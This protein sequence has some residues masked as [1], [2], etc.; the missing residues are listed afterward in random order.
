MKTRIVSIISGVLL[1]IPIFSNAQHSISGT[2]KNE[3]GESLYGAKVKVQELYTG[4]FTDENGVYKIDD[5]ADGE[6][7]LVVSL[8]G[9][10]EW[11]E[12]LVVKG[13]DVEK[14]IVLFKSSVLLDE[15]LAV[16]V[17]A[18]HSTPTT[19]KE[20]S[21]EDIE[22]GNFGQDL[23]YLLQMTPS[24]V[25]T[26]DAGAGVGYTGI[27]IRGV[28]PTRTNVTVNGIPVNDAES[29]GTYWVDMPDLASSVDNI[30]VQRGVGT[31]AN[32]SA[33]FGASINIQMDQVNKKAYGVVDNSYGSFNTWKNTVK[34]G[35]GLIR[36]KF[37]VD[38]RFSRVT[39]D[40]YIDRA[41]S[42]LSSMYISGAWLGKNSNLRATFFT[43]KE[44]TYQAWWGVPGAKLSGDMDSLTGHFYN[45]YYPGGM[46][47]TANDSTNLFGSDS[48]TYNFYT[49][50]NEVDDY[51]QDYY[52]LHFNHKFSKSVRFNAALHYTRGLGY[53]EQYRIEDDFGTYGFD[54]VVVSGD[55]VTTTDLIRRR[56][57]DNHF[58]G[59]IYS[60]NYMKN[61]LQL[62]FGGGANQYK[63]GHYG[64][65]IWA[66]L[67]SNSELGDRF[68]D[69]DATK[70]EIQNYLKATWRNNRFTYFAD[71]Q[72]RH[73]DYNFLG[74][75]LNDN[76]EIMPFEQ[77]VQ[78]NFVNPKAGL[79]FDMNNKNNFYASLAMANRE[80]VRNDFTESTPNSRPSPE[81]LMDIEAGYHFTGSKAYVNANMFYMMYKDQL[82]LTGSVNDVGAY[83]RTNVDNSYRR[84]VEIDGGYMILS[85]LSI[86]LNLTLS[87][88]KIESFTE[89]VDEFDASFNYLGQREI[90]HEN[91]DLAFSPNV[92][93]GAAINY[94]PV[95]G[96]ELQWASKYV[97]KQYLDNTMD[98]TR[99]M[100]AYFISN[101]KIQYTLNDVFF[102]K[103]TFGVLVNNLFNELYENNGYTWGYIYDNYRVT[104]NFY[105]PQAGR[106]FLTRIS[107]HL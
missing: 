62:T 87:Q 25:V 2:V 27:R 94:E 45:N 66:R 99:K 73:V 30:Q 7:T 50:K 5:L 98:D 105:Y 59:G 21:K 42:N 38:T 6:Y 78:F 10:D 100:D 71:V 22:K 49:Y 69:N 35:T 13:A 14:N 18:Q 11:S 102:K 32:G 81:S 46:Y 20:I 77:N 3:D 8:M 40:G 41:T 93:G 79:M 92:I 58:Y 54:P 82:I 15:A 12:S 97:G 9:Y 29:H 65:V 23:P 95:K 17:K 88:N 51:R 28:D 61:G 80:P 67:A 107:I 68:Y 53:Y 52:Q 57:L 39:S 76:G 103:I 86:G 72:F 55:T 47:Q 96:L 106:N 34:A 26:S 64:E 90:V 4:S 60:L 24:T 19:Y 101:L 89:Y 43:G 85:N 63:G 83:A 75:D 84:G 91:S 33:A 104:E 37:T 16:G 70:T 56:W 1:G 74:L 31:S 36:D 44:R 48:R